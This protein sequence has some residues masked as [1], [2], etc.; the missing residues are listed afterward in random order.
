MED[1]SK[2]PVVVL[3]GTLGAGKTTV[4]NLLCNES[5]PVGHNADSTFDLHKG[6]STA[7]FTVIDPPGVGS[8]HDQVEHAARQIFALTYQPITLVALVASDLRAA[9]ISAQIADALKTMTVEVARLCVVVTHSEHRSEADRALIQTQILQANHIPADRVFFSGR[10]M[11]DGVA[12]GI[13]TLCA[14]T[15]NRFTPKVRKELLLHQTEEMR[16]LS[17]DMQEQHAQF[18]KLELALG[19]VAPSLD[20]WRLAL[21]DV[22]RGEVSRSEEE[23]AAL[24]RKNSSAAEHAELC[25]ASIKSDFLKFQTV[26]RMHLSFDI[27]NPNVLQ[28]RYKRCPNCHLIWTLVHGCTGSTFCG[29][30]CWMGGEDNDDDEMSPKV[31]QNWGRRWLRRHN[32]LW[33]WCL[34]TRDKQS[35][36][37]RYSRNRGRPGVGCGTQFSWDTLPVLPQNQLTFLSTFGGTADEAD[38]F[39]EYPEDEAR[40]WTEQLDAKIAQLAAETSQL[41]DVPAAFAVPRRKRKTLREPV[42]EQPADSGRLGPIT[43][44]AKRSRV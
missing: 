36:P 23:A 41:P 43:R 29:A 28:N 42:P 16:A 17:L 39:A 30:R 44:S 25:I 21:L 19:A 26:L 24:V 11:A 40:S 5:M 2:L 33:T 22:Y 6:R 12:A 4:F 7:G 37:P 13:A 8:L 15:A 27:R 38:L 9:R 35:R 32:G 34:L 14:A 31:A 1:E 10:D 3:Y 18:V 20:N